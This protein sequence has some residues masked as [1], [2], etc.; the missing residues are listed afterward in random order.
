MISISWIHQHEFIYEFIHMNSDIWIHDILHDHEFI[1]EFIL[2]IHIIFHDHE[3]ICDISWPMNN[4]FIHEF[5]YMTQW[6]ISWNYAWIHVY[7][8][9]RWADGLLGLW[10]RHQPPNDSSRLPTPSW[11]PCSPMFLWPGST[12][13]ALS[14]PA[15][16]ALHCTHRHRA[17]HRSRPG[18]DW[19][20]GWR[21]LS[22]RPD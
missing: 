4:E 22:S 16:W 2:W 21:A 12:R 6:R 19:A 3:F 15:S 10:Q 9:S 13:S 1:S 14:R 7:Q 20:A 5:M 17:P 11:P 8:G 18:L